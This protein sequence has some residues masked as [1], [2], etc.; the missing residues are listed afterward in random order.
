[1]SE[2]LCDL[3]GHKDAPIRTHQG[4]GSL[5]PGVG[6]K[7]RRCGRKVYTLKAGDRVR[8]AGDFPGDPEA[9]VEGVITSVVELSPSNNVLS[10]GITWD[11]GEY[12]ECTPG[13]LVAL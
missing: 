5:L 3:M 7:C 2:A 6:V 12:G 9:R 1:M 13:E 8:F 11:D 10:Y 4:R